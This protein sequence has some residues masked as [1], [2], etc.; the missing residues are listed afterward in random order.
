MQLLPY[1]AD[2]LGV[3]LGL[4]EQLLPWKGSGSPSLQWGHLPFLTAAV[5]DQA[6]G[7]HGQRRFCPKGFCQALSRHAVTGPFVAVLLM[8]PAA[9]HPGAGPQEALV[10]H[11]HQ[12]VGCWQQHWPVHWG[13]AG[14]R[15]QEL[16]IPLLESRIASSPEDH[17]IHSKVPHLSRG[18]EPSLS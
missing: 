8:S 3:F 4:T 10:L 12:L 17:K 13:V 5:C 9:E 11:G 15:Q 1:S 14:R 6:V 2:Y 18:T 7:R 16:L